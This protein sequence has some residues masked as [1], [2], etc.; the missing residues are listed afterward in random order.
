MTEPRP[1]G[2]AGGAPLCIAAY[3][4]VG[5]DTHAGRGGQGRLGEP[6]GIIVLIRFLYNCGEC[7]ILPPF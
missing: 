1:R 6:F 7:I 5:F 3:L 2:W 4:R